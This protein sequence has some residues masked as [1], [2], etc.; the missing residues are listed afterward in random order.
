MTEKRTI[1]TS[2]LEKEIPGNSIVEFL[3]VNSSVRPGLID[4][5]YIIMCMCICVC[6]GGGEEEGEYVPNISAMG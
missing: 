5:W 3:N 4:N 1:K 6:V 2:A